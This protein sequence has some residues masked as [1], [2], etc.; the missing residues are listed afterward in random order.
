M[1]NSSYRDKSS[2]TKVFPKALGAIPKNRV[3]R[4]AYNGKIDGAAWNSGSVFGVSEAEV[5]GADSGV[6]F[7]K[8]GN[9]A[10]FEAASAIGTGEM[11]M[12][13]INTT[14]GLV[15]KY[16]HTG[17]TA[18]TGQMQHSARP[19]DQM[20]NIVGTCLEIAASSG[21]TFLGWFQPRGL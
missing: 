4:L 17:L 19:V 3:L 16:L 5:V 11:I 9:L 18:L 2:R 6:M 8:P 13:D 10:I 1:V 12:V 14:V 20:N 21:D 15:S 7:T